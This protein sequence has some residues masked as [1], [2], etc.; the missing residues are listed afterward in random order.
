MFISLQKRRNLAQVT[1]L[2]LFV[3]LLFIVLFNIIKYEKKDVLN[4]H[5]E[6][7]RSLKQM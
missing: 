2:V 7:H 3:M 4:Y 6:E 1:Y 5:F